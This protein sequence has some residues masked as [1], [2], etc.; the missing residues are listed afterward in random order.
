MLMSL[1]PLLVLVVFTLA[2][3]LLVIR[4][5]REPGRAVLLWWAGTACVPV[6]IGMNGVGF[7]LLFGSVLAGALIVVTMWTSDVRIRTNAFD[8]MMLALVGTTVLAVAFGGS[9][10]IAFDAVTHWAL[11][12][13]LLRLLTLVVPVARLRRIIVGVGVGVALWAVVEYAF[14]LHVFERMPAVGLENLSAI[15]QQIQ[16][17][18]G[19]ARSEAAF[20][21]AIVLATFLAIAM[22]FALR[23][24]TKL[25]SLVAPVVLMSGIFVTLSRTGFV[26]VAIAGVLTLISR[27]QKYRFVMGAAGLAVSYFALP[28][29]QG[30]GVSVSTSTELAD[31]SAYRDYVFSTAVP[32]THWLGRAVIEYV[33]VD[34]AYLRLALES[35]RIPALCLIGLMLFA[36]WVAI[37]HRPGASTSATVAMGGSMYVVALVTQWELFVFAAAGIAASELQLLRLQSAG[38]SDEGTVKIRD[39]Q[40]DGSPAGSTPWR[41]P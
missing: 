21:T 41:E 37:V 23:S 40:S 30:E 2:A 36:L 1:P 31:S 18:N 7:Q 35:G 10:S 5:G 22:P 4:I 29:V 28:L 25:W 13:F 19:V 34:N 24:Q 11:P 32:Q 15:W 17:R 12:Y 39:A 38:S 9:R 16:I 14:D 3:I 33:S 8:G 6:W 27:R 26:A 20:G